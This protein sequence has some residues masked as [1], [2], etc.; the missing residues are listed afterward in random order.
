M[1]RI[2]TLLLVTISTFETLGQTTTTIK[3]DE[4]LT[5]E[6]LSDL[7]G[8]RFINMY[9]NETYVEYL[10]NN[11]QNLDVQ[12]LMGF[13]TFLKND[14]EFPVAVTM[15]QIRELESISNSTCDFVRVRLDGEFKSDFLAV[16]KITG[17][18]AA[19]EFCDNTVYFLEL[20]SYPVNGLTNHPKKIKS[21]FLR[22]IPFK[23]D[24]DV[25]N[26]KSIRKN[27]VYE[28]LDSI[29]VSNENDT[30]KPFLIGV[31][32][33]FNGGEIF[34]DKIVIFNN[35]GNLVMA[36][37]SGKQKASKDWS[38]GEHLGE[39][40]KTSSQNDFILY[41]YLEDK[42]EAQGSVTFADGSLTLYYSG[43]AHKFV[44]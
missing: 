39:L 23:I 25:S 16:G 20:P 38:K 3:S 4:A 17:I 36:F 35:N 7:S 28:N 42:T 6:F 29:S 41:F 15:D 5:N 21:E 27:L 33:Y 9:Q 2:L 24:Y 43:K 40:K 11:Q 34:F 13:I 32:Q 30:S 37:V 19:F 12:L 10:I 44:K 14:L 8:V 18:V 22:R 1:K 31:Y 26:V